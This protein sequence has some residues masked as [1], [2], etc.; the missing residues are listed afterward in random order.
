MAERVVVIID[1][2]GHDNRSEEVA[3]TTASHNDKDPS[4]LKT[5]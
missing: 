5:V 4:C 2:Q 1:V 3:A